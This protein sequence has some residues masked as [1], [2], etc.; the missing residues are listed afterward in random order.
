MLHLC[1]GPEFM[2]HYTERM[3]KRREEKKSP[4][5]SGIRTHDLKSF[6]LQA[7]AQPL[8]YNRSLGYQDSFISSFY[9]R[10]KK[11]HRRFF[12]AAETRQFQLFSPNSSKI[13]PDPDVIVG[14]TPK[15]L[16][17][18]LAHNY[19][20][21]QVAPLSFWTETSIRAEPIL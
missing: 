21:L 18:P 1:E 3:E 8:C 20:Q 6:T 10:T 19:L 11:C 4:E 16:N 5:S 2:P 14:R 7:C 9:F 17:G 15:G 13:E 12:P